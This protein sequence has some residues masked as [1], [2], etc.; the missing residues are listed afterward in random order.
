[1]RGVQDRR[2]E[3]WGHVRV[4]NARKDGQFG[5]SRGAP[6]PSLYSYLGTSNRGHLLEGCGRRALLKEFGGNWGEEMRV[7]HTGQK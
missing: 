7:Y 5:Q 6:S 1:M 2:L 4:L 3:N